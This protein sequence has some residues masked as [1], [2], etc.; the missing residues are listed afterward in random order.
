MDLYLAKV[1]TERDVNPIQAT[2][3]IERYGLVPTRSVTEPQT[4]VVTSSLD[5][6]SEIEEKDW[7]VHFET[8]FIYSKGEIKKKKVSQ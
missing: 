2:I 4:H 3:D 5:E 8:D 7:T 1:A 6:S